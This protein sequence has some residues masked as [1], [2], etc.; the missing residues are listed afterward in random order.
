MRLEGECDMA[1]QTGKSSRTE[2]APRAGLRHGFTLVEMLAVMVLISI[3]MATVGMSLG[4]ARQI[5]RNTKAEAECRELLNAILEYRSL[6]GEWPGGN[7]A[8][9]EVEAE[10]SFL[11][12]LIDSSKNDSGIVFLN[13]NL[14]SGE[15]WLDPWGSPYVINFPDGSETDPRRTVLETCVSFPFRRVARDVEEGN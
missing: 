13:L 14:A 9:G 4:K 12:P 10:Y 1:R 11:E 7:K 8:K 3:L 6:Y 2:A 5:A 15:K